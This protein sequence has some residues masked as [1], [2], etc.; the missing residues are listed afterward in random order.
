MQMKLQVYAIE[1]TQK[2]NWNYKIL[3]QM[4]T[5]E[6]RSDK[7]WNTYHETNSPRKTFFFL[8]AAIWWIGNWE[9]LK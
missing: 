8:K 1:W 2:R 6:L 7:Q 9:K 5:D 4:K 3:Y